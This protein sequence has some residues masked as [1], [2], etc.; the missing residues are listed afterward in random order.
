MDKRSFEQEMEWFRQ[1]QW[2]QRLAIFH[3]LNEY[4]KKGQIVFTGSSLMEQFP[5]L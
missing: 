4:A 3:N 1:L 5:L 2:T